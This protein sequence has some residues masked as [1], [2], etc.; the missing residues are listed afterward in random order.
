M[1]TRTPDNSATLCWTKE[2]QLTDLRDPLGLTLRV[3]GRLSGQ[4][5]HGV[6]SLTKRARYYSFLPW[7]VADYRAREQG[8]KHDRGLEYALR[9]RET[10]LAMGC[11]LHHHGQECAGLGLNGT[12]RAK[13]WY[14]QRGPGP[15]DLTESFVGRSAGFVKV[16][17]WYIYSAS[18]WSLGLFKGESPEP[19][20]SDETKN[21]RARD[22][23]ELSPL[24]EEVARRYG[25]MVDPLRG[26][27]DAAGSTR[28]SSHESL[29]EWGRNGG[30]CELRDRDAADRDL[31]RDLFFHRCAS[32]GLSHPL[33][34][35]SLLLIMELARRL[36]AEGVPLTKSTFAGAVY[37]N[38]IVFGKRDVSIRWPP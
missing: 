15:S 35:Q 1:S 18:L 6:T 24:G 11:F 30:L 23:L 36:E 22:D 3:A 19:D 17:A 31:L 38:R 5:L 7:C 26:V 33:R 20:E 13:R 16:P 21:T 32:P 12:K 9:I 27:V 8:Q 25:A 2:V 34:R 10:A 28:R 4:L 29:A 14:E 37:S